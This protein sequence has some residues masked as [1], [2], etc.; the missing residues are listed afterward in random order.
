MEAVARLAGGIAHD[1]NNLLS[2]IL[3]FADL[4]ERRLPADER[5]RRPAHQIRLAA[6]RAALL[7][8]QLLGF[9]R[10]QAP[11]PQV[12][13]LN[14][15]ITG[16]HQMLERVIGEDVELRLR[17]GEEIGPV[18]ADPGQLEQVLMNLAVNARDAMPRG[19][20][21]ALE[22]ASA[23]LLDGN[24]VARPAVRFTVADTG[25]GIAPEVMPRLFEPFF[26][27]KGAAKGTGLGLSTVQ[28][29]V[30]RLGG[31][32]EVETEPG[33]GT[34]FHI[35]VPCVEG[36][37]AAP[38]AQARQAVP[39]AQG[40][41]TILLVEDEPPVRALLAELLQEAGYRVREA[42][43][44]RAA[45]AEYTADPRIDLVLTDVVLPDRNGR[46]LVEALAAREP[47]LRVLFMSGYTDD[48]VLG[49]GLPEGIPFV[50][51]PMRPDDLLRMIRGVLEKR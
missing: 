38:R 42:G 43:T 1:F 34:A 3:G 28:G 31:Q 22:T 45:E 40:R 4:L 17:L 18:F 7:T 46:E 13:D 23:R 9:S 27:T 20:L 29:I 33:K 19:G 15:L 47:A 2:V 12:L 10:D 11:Q 5:L 24:G 30:K 44:A 21:L 41:E 26:T 51:K 37:G 16:V 50:R 35:V 32:L 49:Q 8:R 36:A 39:L 25:T 14:Q 6:E 48:E